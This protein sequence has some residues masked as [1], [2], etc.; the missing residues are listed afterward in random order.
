MASDELTPKEVAIREIMMDELA[1]HMI[2][3]FDESSVMGIVK[4]S[5]RTEWEQN[6]QLFR[7]EWSRYESLGA[8]IKR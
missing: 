5:L 8:K 6:P 1:E 7:E 3:D 4:A 2:Q